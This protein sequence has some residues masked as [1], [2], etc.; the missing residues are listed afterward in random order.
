[1]KTEDKKTGEDKFFPVFSHFNV[2]NLMNTEGLDNLLDAE[3][4]L[5]GSLTEDD[6]MKRAE[7]MLK[8]WRQY[9]TEVASNAA[10]YSQKE[11][12]VTIPPVTQYDK[13]DDYY[14]TVFH[15]L[16]HFT[17]PRL[18]R[19]MSS[20]ADKKNYA[21]EELVAEIG[22]SMLC[23]H[24]GLDYS[25]QHTAYIQSWLKLLGDDNKKFL[26]ASSLANKAVKYILGEQSEV[27]N[28]N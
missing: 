12:H 8:P 13:I 19:D 26:K 7:T 24:A 10:Y 6:R 21:F 16:I 20:G 15:E 5:N 25:S 3:I 22:A 1:M 28:G 9:M 11:D 2:F 18:G 14:A 27:Q 4:D 17:G 23:C